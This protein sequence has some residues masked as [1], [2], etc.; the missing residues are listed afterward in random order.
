MAV[1]LYLIL[2]FI[3]LASCSM[4]DRDNSFD[5]EGDNFCEECYASSSS[6]SSSSS[7]AKYG[8]P[9]DNIIY[10]TLEYEG[11]I[12]KTVVIGEQTWMAENLNYKV[13]GSKCYYDNQL[14]CDRYGRLYNWAMAMDIEQANNNYDWNGSDEK[15]RGICPKGWHLP[16]NAE[17]DELKNFIEEDSNCSDCAGSLLR[18]IEEDE[19]LGYSYNNYG[20]SALA[21]GFF[22][23]DYTSYYYGGQF[24]GWLTSTEEENTIDK[25]YII[26]M[27]VGYDYLGVSNYYEKSSFLPV[28]CVMD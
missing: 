7:Y 26:V 19:W 23:N 15:H 22:V 6:E 9:N 17:W 4:P 28:R 1:K 11:Q 3:L 12:Y 2:A 5:P 21:A 13:N 18:S 24:T 27:G 8:V 20:F 16:S 14:N 10:G 25:S